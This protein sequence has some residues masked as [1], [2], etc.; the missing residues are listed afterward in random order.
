MGIY[1]KN[2]DYVVTNNGRSSIDIYLKNKSPQGEYDMK[3]IM[4]ENIPVSGYRILGPIK[5][6]QESGEHIIPILIGVAK[7]VKLVNLLIINVK[8]EGLLNY[9]S[10]GINIDETIFVLSER[11]TGTNFFSNKIAGMNAKDIKSIVSS[12]SRKKV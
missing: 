11:K 5:T 12:V 2:G 6:S 9:L 4:E 8:C 3:K 1:F 10:N 7:N